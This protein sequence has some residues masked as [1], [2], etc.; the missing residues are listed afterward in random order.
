M[1]L[2]WDRG[3]RMAPSVDG[4]TVTHEGEGADGTL[5]GLEMERGRHRITVKVRRSERG[6]GFLYV[7]VCATDHR[8]GQW[9]A[10][11]FVPGRY[12]GDLAWGFC[13]LNGHL[14]HTGDPS[15]WGTRG[16]KLMGGD[17]DGRADGLVVVVLVDMDARSLKFQ[18]DGGVGHRALSRLRDTPVPATP[19]S[20]RPPRVPAPASL[21]VSPRAVGG[22]QVP[23]RTRTSSFLRQCGCGRSSL[24]KGTRCRSSGTG[25]PP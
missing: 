7:G 2:R 17:L 23:S 21:T 13:P 19:A 18:M 5:G 4:S 16:R 20:R 9:P 8:L 6:R 12:H 11:E 22:G 25:A 15:E 10:A 3:L 1:A 14:H 24:T